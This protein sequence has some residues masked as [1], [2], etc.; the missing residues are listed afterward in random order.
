VDPF[1]GSGTIPIEATLIAARVTPGLL[2]K[3]ED[4]ALSFLVPEALDVLRKEHGAAASE[5]LDRP[6]HPVR[7]SDTSSETLETARANARRAGV[8]DWLEF[9]RRD[10]RQID[11][12]GA[13]IV[14]N[15][16]YGERLEDPAAAAE[17]LR[18]FT[19]RVKH[20]AVGS[21][22]TLVVPRGDLE[23]SVGLRPDRKLA[24][25]S[26]PLRLRYLSYEIQ[27]GRF[28]REAGA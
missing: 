14:T 13:W 27:A 8:A 7:G 23:K 21:R 3:P 28:D 2:R 19:H 25:E 18:A 5:R 1:C 22:L 4:F 20:H 11:A 17:L 9:E 24:V 10:A 16:P 15:P 12:P 6:P 26:G